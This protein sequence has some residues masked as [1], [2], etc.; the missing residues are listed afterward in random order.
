MNAI[1]LI[2]KF[3]LNVSLVGFPVQVLTIF[4]G[5]KAYLK[6]TDDPNNRITITVAIALWIV[7]AISNAIPGFYFEKISQYPSGTL[8]QFYLLLWVVWVA[9]NLGIYSFF[10][11]MPFYV[12]SWLWM[13]IFS[14]TIC[15]LPLMVI[16]L[17]AYRLG[18]K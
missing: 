5:P 8:V 16:N 3:L 17:V 12:S 14:F 2:G 18:K 11:S 6:A 9:T 15:F 13:S 7:L 10:S 1:S 4:M